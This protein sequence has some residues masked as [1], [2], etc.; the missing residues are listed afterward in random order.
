M[1]ERN[2]KETEMNLGEIAVKTAAE[3]AV[4]WMNQNNAK[5]ESTDS[6]CE[7]I[8]AMVKIRL[9]EALKDAKDAFDANMGACA[10]QTFIASMRLAGIEA[11]KECAIPR[12]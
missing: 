1:I 9:P 8:K 6:F 7:S 12:Q 10:E 11:A 5:P 4:V 3:S 2:K